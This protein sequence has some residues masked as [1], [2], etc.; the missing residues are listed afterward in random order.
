[1]RPPNTHNIREF[2]NRGQNIVG[3]GLMFDKE[4]ISN[5]TKELTDVLAYILQLENKLGE[6]EE[7]LKNVDI[8]QVQMVGDNF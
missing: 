7:Q 5:V 4:T 6:V 2:I 1:M 3:N 8:I